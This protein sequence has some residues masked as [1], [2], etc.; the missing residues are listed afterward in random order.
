M[1]VFFP[2]EKPRSSA[3]ILIFFSWLAVNY[4]GQ[5]FYCGVSL[6]S[7]RCLLISSVFRGI[8]SI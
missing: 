2:S 6:E 5:F 4:H 8:L 1:R 7:E 3:S